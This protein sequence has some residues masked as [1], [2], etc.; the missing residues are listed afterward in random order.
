MKLALLHSQP[1]KHHQLNKRTKFLSRDDVSS[2]VKMVKKMVDGRG[3]APGR[4]G[5]A[6]S[7]P[8]L[9]ALL[10]G[11]ALGGEEGR[12][13]EQER[14]EVGRDKERKGWEGKGG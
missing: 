9:L 8:S 11:N 1:A 14:E 6:Y 12:R 7:A 3:S 4:A 10:R 13:E 5:R 2:A